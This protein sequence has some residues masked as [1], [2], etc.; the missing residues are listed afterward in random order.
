MFNVPSLLLEIT[1][2]AVAAML[3]WS[4]MKRLMVDD[5]QRFER[6]TPRVD[7][8]NARRS[9]AAGDAARRMPSQV[10]AL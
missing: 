9:P 7:P 10:T 1:V 3:L 5:A 8:S 6:R 4:T 2:V